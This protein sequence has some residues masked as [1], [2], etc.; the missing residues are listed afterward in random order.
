MP[1]ART[2]RA[3]S[4]A[5]VAGVGQGSAFGVILGTN[6]NV[7]VID[8]GT[9]ASITASVST[10]TISPTATIATATAP[11]SLVSEAIADQGGSLKTVNNAGTISPSTPR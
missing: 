11:F 8:V 9:N 10:N 1:R 7:P 2:R 5:Q 4:R 6:S 3:R